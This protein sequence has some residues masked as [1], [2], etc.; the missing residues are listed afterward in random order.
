MAAVCPS[1]VSGCMV[2]FIRED[3]CGNPLVGG[4]FTNNMI[5][6][7]G[8][9]S[10]SLT[11]DVENGGAIFERNMCGDPC[12]NERECAVTKGYNGKLR[13]CKI[14][15][16]VL[17][18]LGVSSPLFDNN[19]DIIGGKMRS[20]ASQN[21]TNAS[22]R[23]WGRTPRRCADGSVPFVVSYIPRAM[24]FVL[25]S[26]LAWQHNTLQ[27]WEIDFYVRSSSSVFSDPTGMFTDSE[28]RDT[29]FVWKAW[30][31]ALPSATP[32]CQFETI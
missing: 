23:I 16:G 5:R 30:S 1:V 12:V 21:C 10:V 14:D 25:T 18:L 11:P 28:V 20:E 32:L 9:I 3:E 6:T 8:L 31:G 13:L 2:E 27:T 22:M 15:S 19:L 24:D 26:E 17:D 7:T 29:P 4:A